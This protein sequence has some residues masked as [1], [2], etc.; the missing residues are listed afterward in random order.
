MSNWLVTGAGGMLGR[1]L[2]A[3]LTGRPDVRLT[4]LHRS[5]L[6]IAD[7]EAAEAAVAGQSVVINAAAWTNV[8]AAE[9][10][11][12][13]A[14]AVNGTAVA[15]LARA[16]AA[17]GA[18][19]LHVSTDYVF[20]GD[21]REPYAEDAPTS[22]VNAYGRGKLVGERAVIETMP[23]SGFVVRTAWLYTRARDRP[24]FLATMLRL[25]G[26]RETLTVV[27]D[28]RGQPTWSGALAGRLVELGDAALAG[29]APA[30]IYHGT[31][32]GETTWCGFARAIF[33]QAGLDPER[34]RPI[35]TAE[36]PLPAPRPAYSV[37]GHHRWTL[38][39]LGPMPD[40]RQSLADA[41]ASES[42]GPDARPGAPADVV[43]PVGQL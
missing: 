18:L 16:C 7:P 43:T 11:E 15:H 14:T 37:L 5:D 21:A 22:P 30:G 12:E 40:W 9:A 29:R 26:E 34:V 25:A 17:S 39:G 13:R 28:Q 3:A 33:A 23:E 19:L 24:N 6:D 8:D 20:P 31:G 27:D 10:H 1:D 38:A 35:T 41:F 36:F 4:A 42:I 32:S 2:V